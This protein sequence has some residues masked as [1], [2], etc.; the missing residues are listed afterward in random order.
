MKLPKLFLISTVFIFLCL[1]WTVAQEPDFLNP[2]TVDENTVLL[3]HFDGDLTNASELSD[4]ASGQGKILFVGSANANLGQAV[5]VQNEILADTSQMTVPHADVLNC[6]G[7][8]TIE[9]W[10]SAVTYA[11]STSSNWWPRFPVVIAKGGHPFGYWADKPWVIKLDQFNHNLRPFIKHQFEGQAW[12]EGWQEYAG[13]VN[14][15]ELLNW[16][17]FVLVGDTLN[18]TGAYMLHDADGNLI[19]ISTGMRETPDFIN[20]FPII[21]GGEGWIGGYGRINMIYDEIR[22][23]NVVRPYEFPPI[24]GNVIQ[25]YTDRLGGNAMPDEAVEISADV[26]VLGSSTLS[27]NPTLHYRFGSEGSFI[28]MAMTQ[29]DSTFTAELPGQESGTF[30]EYYISAETVNG[31]RLTYPKDA[32]R[33]VDPV[34]NGVGWW[35]A[36]EMTL[37]LTFEGESATDLSDYGQE[38]LLF[39][40]NISYSSDVAP[41]AGG[42][43]SLNI[44][45]TEGLPDTSYLEIPPPSPFINSS[46]EGYVLDFWF[47]PTSFDHHSRHYVWN[48]GIGSVE[49]FAPPEFPYGY[50]TNGGGAVLDWPFELPLNKW[51]RVRMGRTIDF[52]F[53]EFYDQNDSLLFLRTVLHSPD[54]VEGW[55]EQRPHSNAA[56]TMGRRPRYELEA[57]AHMFVDNVKFYNYPHDAPGALLGATVPS[58]IQTPD[59]GVDVVVTSSGAATWFLSQVK[60]QV[61]PG[62]GDWQAVDLTPLGENDFGAQIPG[63]PSKS[64]VQFYFR[65]EDQ[66]GRI[67]TYPADA[68]D[69]ENYYALGFLEEGTQEKEVVLD[70]DFEEGAPGP[71]VNHST[72]GSVASLMEGAQYVDDAAEGN[73]ALEV[74]GSG[75]VATIKAPFIGSDNYTV[76][77]WFKADSSIA[78]N[79][80][81]MSKRGQKFAWHQGQF[82]LREVGGPDSPKMEFRVTCDDDGSAK[83]FATSI[84][85][86]LDRWYHAVAEVVTDTFYF[87]L[88]TDK[89]SL[90]GAAGTALSGA[91]LNEPEGPLTIGG[92]V[93]SD[94]STQ[95]YPGKFDKIQIL[96]YARTLV[97]SIDDENRVD[98]PTEF[99]LSQNYPNPFNP[100]TTINFDVPRQDRVKLVVYDMLGRKVVELMN[101]QLTAGRYTVE[102]NGKNENG[103]SVAS[104]AYFYRL[105]AENGK[106]SKVRK[107][108]ILR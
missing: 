74:D 71:P 75:G 8:F 90:V 88:Y 4:D 3:L 38:V 42:T 99:Y 21:M 59:Q 25:V 5:W 66:Y 96:N 93:P 47:K 29:G 80:F 78:A 70:I 23:S 82:R 77:F 87:A 18:Q 73:Y 56:I 62:D 57:T 35:N 49:T 108:L 2:Y 63:Q 76:D 41:G 14:S 55:M 12:S 81:V 103:R 58:G 89:D 30:A 101:K 37:H 1:N 94:R 54:A 72:Y 33:A 48:G 104:G 24:I 7:N 91:A 19:D 43:T 28:E 85:Y 26:R 107:M 46:L 20:E 44:N 100:T 98:L 86:E 65:F 40:D 9:G 79:D 68:E 60:Y 36:E 106:F 13:A 11:T 69:N 83:Q 53:T 10:I 95:Q 45:S 102:W 15:I 6:E 39:G 27:G 34:L 51:L 31:D 105:D 67:A 97:T 50:R 61:F 16:Y 84:P 64:M 92:V 22:I 32:E 52:D 17:H